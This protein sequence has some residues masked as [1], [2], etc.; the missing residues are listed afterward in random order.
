ME[1]VFNLSDSKN[2][3]EALAFYLAFLIS[4]LTLVFIVGAVI[5]IIGG[6]EKIEEATETAVKMGHIFAIIFTF[7]L[8]GLILKSKGLINRFGSI[9]IV[10]LASLLSVFTGLL[11]S[12]IPLAYLTTLPS[13][14]SALKEESE[15]K[16]PTN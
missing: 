11:V 15:E 4:F 13:K 5:G 9:A 7:V 8:G 10:L 3:K 2:W 12:L 16:V 6:E 1:N 14:S